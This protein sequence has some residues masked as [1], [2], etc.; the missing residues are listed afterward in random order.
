M[1]K[2]IKN[3]VAYFALYGDQINEWKTM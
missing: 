1:K 3:I 2:I